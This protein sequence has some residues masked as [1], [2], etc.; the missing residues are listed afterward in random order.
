MAKLA[1]G[2]IHFIQAILG[3][4]PEDIKRAMDSLYE[5]ENAAYKERQQSLKS[6]FR[7]T[8][9][10]PAGMEYNVAYA[11]AQLLGAITLFLSESVIDSAKALYKLRKAFQTFD[12]VNKQLSSSNLSRTLSSGVAAST[13]N[14]SNISGSLKSRSSSISIRS[15]KQDKSRD[16]GIVSSE[17]LKNPQIAERAKAFHKARL[18]RAR[19]FDGKDVDHETIINNALFDLGLEN[20]SP[21][22]AGQ[23]TV[24]EYIT[25]AIYACYGL[26]QLVISIIP[27][28]LGRVLSVVGFHGTKEEGLNMLWKGATSHMNIHGSIA[29][30]ALLQF[31][32]GP[33]QVS[34]IDLPPSKIKLPEHSTDGE[35]VIP[36]DVSD[37]VQTKLAL[38]IAL[39]RAAKHYPKGP[40]WQLQE[41]RMKASEG[42]LRE[43]VAIM[44]DTSRGPINLRQVEGLMLF[45]KTMFIVSLH[46][47]E[48]A[49][50]NFIRLIE[51][52]SWSHMFYTYLAGISHVELYR[53]NKETNPEKAQKSLEF[54]EQC[55]KKAP[56]YLGK[57]K[58]LS[59]P[60]PFDTFVLR[61]LAL[62]KE[63]ATSQKLGIVDAIG[64]SP[65]HEIIYFWNG[66]GR[67]PNDDLEKSLTYLAYSAP[68]SPPKAPLPEVEDEALMRYLLQAVV[69]RNLGRTQEGYDLLTQKVLP[70]VYHS[71]GRGTYKNGL[72]KV[73]FTK[74]HRDPWVAPSA[75]YEMAVFEWTIHGVEKIGL[76]RDYLE[77]AASWG[78]DYELST[79]VGLRIKSAVER[80]SE[81]NK[82]VS[83]KSS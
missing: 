37:L 66:F 72:P 63:I 15:N 16:D 33:T 77:M 34:G 29:L 20:D 8:L 4:E 82:T 54:A 31:Y 2:V 65:A 12:E 28:G 49:A 78:D 57:R 60:M 17:S 74:N 47:Y 41:G 19:A 14:L 80:L 44:D 64:T 39:A 51:L 76:V 3:F 46:G 40:L 75:I 25:S 79:R 70:K 69:L 26:L 35:L 71:G 5:A 7:S 81:V 27:A 59:R 48:V 45:D 11:E 32:D 50:P 9:S 38:K 18:S 42:K 53:Q 73:V 24:D 30:L 21:K 1:I 67:M 61:K 52:S 10:F 56:S 23:D 58:V 62:W 22:K 6:G 43:A 83:E 55:F 68:D 13:P 36:D